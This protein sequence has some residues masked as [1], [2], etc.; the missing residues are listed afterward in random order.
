MFEE[1]A[2]R[3]FGRD[4][5]VGGSV[6]VRL[7]P[8]PYVRFEKL[9]IADTSGVTGAPLFRADSFTMW[10][11]VPPL[12]KGVFEARQVELEKP[13]VRLAVDRTGKPN[14]TDLSIRP[15]GLPFVPADVTLQS[16]KIAGGEIAYD[17][18]GVGTLAR[19]TGIEGDLSA[20]GLRGPFAFRGTIASGE[21]DESDRRQFRIGTGEIAEDYKTRLQV[22][23]QEGGQGAR[24]IPSKVPCQASTAGPGSQAI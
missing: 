7:L 17:A 11:S 2:S 18:A 10:L 9:R 8:T 14:W 24:A 4:V 21:G 20:R 16:V 12:L 19:I 23:V 6:N 15:G 13:V 5:R 22:V 1:E 3:I